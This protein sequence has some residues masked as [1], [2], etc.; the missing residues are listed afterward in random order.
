MFQANLMKERKKDQ[1]RASGKIPGSIMTGSSSPAMASKN[2]NGVNGE[3]PQLSAM[4]RLKSVLS[5]P[6]QKPTTRRKVPMLNNSAKIRTAGQDA[7]IRTQLSQM[8]PRAPSNQD[9]ELD[10][11]R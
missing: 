2:G 1:I 9:S 8:V 11:L 6:Q 10:L 3:R 5:R 7:K 4:D